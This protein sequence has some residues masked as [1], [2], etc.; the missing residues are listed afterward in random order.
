MLP[1]YNQKETHM[2]MIK[3]TGWLAALTITFAVFQPSAANAETLGDMLRESGWDRILG[4]WVDAD[5]DGTMFQLTYAW[6]FQ[7]TLIEVSSQGPSRKSTG[8]IGRH[9]KTGAVHSVGADDKGGGSIGTWGTE[10]DDAVLDMSYVT[11]EGEEGS[12]QVRY[13]LEDDDTLL[14]S[15]GQEQTTKIKMK[16][17]K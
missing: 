14:V 10:G 1:C 11:A 2:K 5:S 12:V 16:R 6:K 17:K 7:D 15:F 8:L 4:T 9:P 13:H 3:W